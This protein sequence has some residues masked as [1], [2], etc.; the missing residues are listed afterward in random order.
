MTELAYNKPEP[1]GILDL[2]DQVSR[3]A[4]PEELYSER[5]EDEVL[6]TSVPESVPHSPHTVYVRATRTLQHV[7]ALRTPPAPLASR[8]FSSAENFT[9]FSSDVPLLENVDPNY[10]YVNQICLNPAQE[11]VAV[12]TKTAPAKSRVVRA[13][14]RSQEQSAAQSVV[15]GLTHADNCPLCAQHRREVAARRNSHPQ[16]VVV[17][18]QAPETAASSE[19]SSSAPAVVANS[20]VAEITLTQTIAPASSPI[21]LPTGSAP[22]LAAPVSQASDIVTVSQSENSSQAPATEVPVALP[23][24]P[25]RTATAPETVELA[26]TS[27]QGSYESAEPVIFASQAGGVAVGLNEGPVV[28]AVAPKKVSSQAGQA[29][30]VQYSRPVV[31]ETP[32]RAVAAAQEHAPASI[33]GIRIHEEG[34]P[35]RGKNILAAT[36]NAKRGDRSPGSHS[37][38]TAERAVAQR[39]ADQAA[40]A[41]TKDR[42]E[43][44]AA[45]FALSS[46]AALAGQALA[47]QSG[48]SERRELGSAVSQLNRPLDQVAGNG[49]KGFDFN[50]RG[51]DR[52]VENIQF[53][54]DVGLD[55]VSEEVFDGDLPE[56]FFIPVDVNV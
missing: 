15:S 21:T 13:P 44:E 32:E 52:A 41:G 5:A 48:T 31:V 2:D 42:Q 56:A 23:A 22:T 30:I 11:F 54:S 7:E 1:I 43:K 37:A 18:E 19:V 50:D 26:N 45:R 10:D 24:S 12:A 47:G 55:G 49:G 40:I 9:G 4:E 3:P 51:R 16:V 6:A 38:V 27:S 35:A 17:A 34:E 28:V 29:P 25:F 8:L 39:N 46:Q 53:Y 36:K 33:T 20:P 14:S